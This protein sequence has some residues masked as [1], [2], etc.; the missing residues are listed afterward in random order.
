ME[1]MQRGVYGSGSGV[2]DANPQSNAAPSEFSPEQNDN[3]PGN[4]NT[5]GEGNDPWSGGDGGSP[6][7]GGEGGGGGW[8]D[9]I[10]DFFSD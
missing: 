3:Q 4:D 10:S 8:L 7:G 5:W 1:A 2:D 9:T 6:G